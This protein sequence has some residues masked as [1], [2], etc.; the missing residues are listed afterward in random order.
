V[1]GE[2]SICPV[3]SETSMR[4][5]PGTDRPVVGFRTVLCDEDGLVY[6]P[7]SSS[8]DRPM[9]KCKWFDSESGACQASVT[10]TVGRLKKQADD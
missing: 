6:L 5:V 10:R 2:K 3:L 4:K 9:G 7:E 1:A 8:L